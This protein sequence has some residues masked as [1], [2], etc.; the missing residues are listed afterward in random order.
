MKALFAAG[1]MVLALSAL[2]PA[3]RADGPRPS[4]E[5][6]WP[7]ITDPNAVAGYAYPLYQYQN[8][9]QS[10]SAIAPHY[11]WQEGYNPH[12]KWH[13]GWVLVQ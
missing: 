1:A 7:G 3:A 8:Q 13:S 6:N 5:N 11:E 10:P 9:Y 4:S 2:S 12:G